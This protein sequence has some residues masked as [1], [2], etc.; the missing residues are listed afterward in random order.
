RQTGSVMNSMAPPQDYGM[1]EGRVVGR[2]RVDTT[3]G[4]PTPAHYRAHF[5]LDGSVGENDASNLFRLR[6]EILWLGRLADNHHAMFRVAQQAYER[7]FEAR[8]RHESI[9]IIDALY[10]TLRHWNRDNWVR[11]T[12]TEARER[13]NRLLDFHWE[14][15]RTSGTVRDMRVRSA[16]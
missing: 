2:V 15:L 10:G 5:N 9:A 13:F 3:P 7:I 14:R 16:G 12:I 8:T 1:E 4:D 6:S 11:I